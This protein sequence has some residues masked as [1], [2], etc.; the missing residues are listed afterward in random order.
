M[1]T[2]NFAVNVDDA[3]YQTAQGRAQA[4]GKSLDQALLELLG[5]YAKDAPAVTSYTV[6]RGDTLSKIARTVYGDPYQYPLIQKANNLSTPGNIW[7]GQVLVIPA[8][9]GTT[10][11]PLRRPPL[12]QFHLLPEPH[13]P[14]DR[15]RHV[16]G[17]R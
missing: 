5:V 7:V 11:P 14:L 8:I 2:Q 16:H 17:A 9:A 1:V 10:P 6:Q 12:H 15:A 4:E 3:V 13:R